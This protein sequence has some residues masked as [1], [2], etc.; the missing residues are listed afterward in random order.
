M[1]DNPITIDDLKQAL[2]DAFSGAK[3]THRIG[4]Q[5][6]PAW[7]IEMER[8]AAERRQKL[9][10][11]IDAALGIDRNAPYVGHVAKPRTPQRKNRR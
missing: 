1:S 11:E 8:E 5:P 10:A 2:R 7:E 3:P 6:R 4:G 9:D